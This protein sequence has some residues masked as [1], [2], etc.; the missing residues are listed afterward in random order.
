QRI[1]T[2]LENGSFTIEKILIYEFIQTKDPEYLAFLAEE[3]D[4]RIDA[5]SAARS[6]LTTFTKQVE[7]VRSKGRKY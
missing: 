6:I 5:K 2:Y 4:K 1:R 3:L 7:L